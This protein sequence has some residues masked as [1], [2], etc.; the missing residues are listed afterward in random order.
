HTGSAILTFLALALMFAPEL[1]AQ[2]LVIGR[3][4]DK[5]TGEGLP[6][7]NVQIVGTVMG[8]STNLR[9][10]FMVRRVPYGTYTLK[11]SM[12]GYKK[13]I[14][15]EVRVVAGDTAFVFARLEETFIEIDPVV[16]TASKWQKEAASTPATV[17][18]L[19]AREIMDRSPIKIEDALETA[20]GV[21]I[22]QESVNIR[23]SDG[24]TRGV[25]SRV[26]VMI[27]DVPVM[28][29]DFGAVNWFMISPADI[30]RAE[31]VRGAGSAL[32][33]SSAMGGVI[34][35][36]TR[37]P[38]PQSRTYI[39]SVV[40][41][42]DE[43]NEEGW[44]WSDELLNFQRTDFTTSRQFGNFGFRVS[45]GF[46]RS[47]GY[48][49]NGEFLRFNGSAKLNYRFPNASRLTVFG[50]FMHDD[51][52]IFIRW[53]SQ[54]RALSVPE[55]E[56]NK[57]Q[58]Q[59]G[60]TVFAKYH[61]P[62]SSKMAIEARAYF[63]R[64]LLGTAVTS[65]GTFSPALGLGGAIQGNFI[66]TPS[67][68]IVYGADFKRDQVKS[69]TTLYGQRDA[70]LAAPYAQIEWSL[71][72]NL[73]LTLGVRYDRYE[74]FSDLRARFGEG[75]SYDHVSPKV[76]LNFQP[77]ETT[78]LR[79]SVANGFKFPIV[80]QLFLSFDA[81]GFTFRPS[82]ELKPEESWTYEIGWRQKITPTW[83]FEVNGFFTEVDNLIDIDLSANL[84]ARF[85][86]TEQARIRGIEF[87]T[88][89]RWWNNRL[90]L[91]GNFLLM[92][93]ED[94]VRDQLLPYRQRFLA[95][96]APSIRL[97]DF[98]LQVDYKYASK[99]EV[100]QLSSFPQLVAQKVLD[101]RLFYYTNKYAVYVG[102]N[103]LG[104]YNYTLRDE[105]L[106]EI[107]NYVVGY[108]M[109]F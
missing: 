18:V 30:E 26:L 65:G 11:V 88:N 63:N 102:V 72:R 83:F 55:T 19:T 50:N 108:M 48:H 82:P 73:N 52:D 10:A 1:F 68:S 64:F 96:V 8:A 90:G 107:R 15:P 23:G 66:P 103:N 58:D 60:I 77:F 35:F 100:Y 32:Y 41:V 101:A 106:E 39:R 28:N 29:S 78:T 92:D 80:A 33:G 5:K 105:S 12:L 21:Q 9:G 46:S 4:T 53:Q 85:A 94:Q 42:Y 20:A 79:G 104:N 54:R 69:D 31:I 14:F 93:P 87:V 37:D 62:I 51:S 99:Q 67:L 7:A 22:V 3:V 71:R 6:G 74:I 2:G 84:E 75:R 95:F 45:G 17:E 34:N 98:E 70:I 36:I 27:D 61:L 91:K 57:E 49:E 86:N 89:G 38:A 40:G 97:G 25:G 16:I 44:D 13:K 109:E 56:R 43:P 47:T 24:Y 59:N 76:G 81:A